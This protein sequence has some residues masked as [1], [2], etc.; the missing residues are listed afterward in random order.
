LQLLDRDETGASRYQIEATLE[1]RAFFAALQLE[2]DTIRLPPNLYL[3]ATMNSADQGVFPLDTAFRRRWNYVYKGYTES[4]AY[5][6]ECALVRYGGRHYGWDA[7]RGAIN[8][9]LISVGIHEDKL[10]GPYFLTLPQLSDPNAILEKLFLYLWDDVL[11]FRQESL[12]IGKSFSAV[13]VGWANG[14]GEPLKLTIPEPVS[15]VAG[16]ADVVGSDTAVDRMP[17]GS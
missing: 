9:F 7:F 12:F 13:G 2:R 11:R 15:E 1:Q 5:P 3:W 16:T 4:C 8:D 14:H 6:P 17:T 10:I